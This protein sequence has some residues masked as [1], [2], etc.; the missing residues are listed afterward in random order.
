MR[1]A[2]QVSNVIIAG[3]AVGATPLP[4]AL[5]IDGVQDYI[6]IYTNSATATQAINRNTFLG[7]ASA[8][9]G[10][11]D[12]QSLSNKTFGNSN[13]YTAKDGSFTLQNTSDLTKQGTFSLSGLTTG[14]TRIY[15]FPDYNAT[16]ASLA[17]TE[18]LTN[19]TL[20]SPTITAPTITNATLSSDAIT[21]FTTSNSGTIY[22]IG[23]TAGVVQ[24]S[25]SILGGALTNSSVTASKLSTGAQ[26]A[27]VLTN[28]TTGSASYT[29]LATTSD[30]I[31]VT[32]GVN[33]LLLISISGLLSNSSANNPAQMSFALSGANTQAASDAFSILYEPYAGNGIGTMGAAFLVTS[34]SGGSTVVKLKYKCNIGGTSSFANRRVAAVPL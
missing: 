3:T 28:E 14:N 15:S 25:N 19:K 13:T 1:G 9:A 23:V 17:G 20:T 2:V 16:L 32:V 18:T 22:G 10:L 29:D 33:G 12:S 7:L 31:T 11:T 6:P 30:T 8:P 27:V 24:T 4:V 21:G 34:L 26:A 5:T